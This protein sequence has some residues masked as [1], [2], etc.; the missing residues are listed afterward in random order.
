MRT[1]ELIGVFGP[2]GVFYPQ[3][4]SAHDSSGNVK[5]RLIRRGN[6]VYGKDA[7]VS[8][9]SDDGTRLY[10][11]V[12]HATYGEYDIGRTRGAHPT[13]KPVDLLRLLIRMYTEP[14][15]WWPTRSWAAVRPAS[16]PNWKAVASGAAN[17]TKVGS[18]PQ[19]KES[20]IPWCSQ[21]STASRGRCW[22]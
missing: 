22:T 1:H 5:T 16:P 3:R 17:A 9:F 7:R 6:R 4:H 2:A 13:A 14:A 15:T 21:R 19:V 8:A 12:L 20:T 11:D 10:G 18:V